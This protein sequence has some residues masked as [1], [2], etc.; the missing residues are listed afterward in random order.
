MCVQSTGEEVDR[1][2]SVFASPVLGIEVRAR[3]QLDVEL[4]RIHRSTIVNGRFVGVVQRDDLGRLMVR[5]HGRTEQLYVSK[6]HDALGR[7]G[8]F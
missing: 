1:Q 6:A 4:W 2:A 3:G 5:M 7:D 8:I